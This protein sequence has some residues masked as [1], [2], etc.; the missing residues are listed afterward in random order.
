MTDIASF[1][2]FSC[3]EE[4]YSAESQRRLSEIKY[5]VDDDFLVK[6]WET[7]FHNILQPCLHLFKVTP[8]ELHTK[9]QWATVIMHMYF[10]VYVMTEGQAEV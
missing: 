5:C 2:M 10:I 6:L 7:L 8:T 1:T 3:T 9:E 4:T